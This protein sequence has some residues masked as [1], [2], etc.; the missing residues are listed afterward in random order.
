MPRK[1]PARGSALYA[2]IGRALVDEKYRERIMKTGQQ[3]AV[4]NEVL[5][6]APTAS[7]L[8]AF[9]KALKA[10]N[11]LYGTFGLRPYSA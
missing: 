6:R 3:R 5:G 10:V 1:D 9:R 4:L 8:A 11:D 2:L 7:D